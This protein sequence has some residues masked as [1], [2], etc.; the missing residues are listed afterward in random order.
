MPWR[1]KPNS[2]LRYLTTGRPADMKAEG[3]RTISAAQLAGSILVRIGLK[4][5]IAARA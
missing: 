4:S 2:R 1:R 3:I 5:L